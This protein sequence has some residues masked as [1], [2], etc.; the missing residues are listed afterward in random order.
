VGLRATLEVPRRVRLVAP[1]RPAERDDRLVRA[2]RDDRVLLRDV[3]DDRVVASADLERDFGGE[4]IE[5]AAA[6]RLFGDAQPAVAR[7]LLQRFLDLG[8]P[9]GDGAVGDVLERTAPA[10]VVVGF[11]D[12]VD[13]R[14]LRDL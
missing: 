2:N 13:D 5:S 12:A 7:G 1:G 8:R 14:L 10:D 9:G 11:D 4:G 3:D 6:A